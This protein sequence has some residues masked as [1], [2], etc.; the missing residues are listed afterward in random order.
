MSDLEAALEAVLARIKKYRHLYEQNE[1]A[2]RDQIVNPILRSLGW[3]T[4]NP[5]EVQPNVSMEEGVPDYSLLKG[6]KPVLFM[7]AK[8][9]GVDVE[10]RD[11]IRQ[12]AK[13]G[14]GEGTKYGILTNGVVWIL[15]KSFE[16]GTTLAERAVWKVDLERERSEATL[17]K[18]NTI[19]RENIGQIENLV[20]RAQ[21]LEETWASILEEPQEMVSG[22]TPVV[23]NLI[24]EA[25]PGYHFEDG[26]IED[27]VK[28]RLRDMI[29]GIAPAAVTYEDEGALEPTRLH[30]ERPRRMKLAGE[31][32]ELQNA[33]EILVNTANWLIRKGRLKAT[34]CPIPAGYK[35]YLIHKEPKHRYGNGFRAPRKLIGGLYIETHYSTVA[36]INNARVLLETYGFPPDML[37]VQ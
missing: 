5:E 26:E 32:F 1:M 28:E 2:V 16:E 22:L 24:S 27:F 30:G 33:F 31:S 14:F 36:C 9:L 19:S 10:Q 17:R 4:E 37:T 7:E 18:L 8:K 15:F 34:D 23:Q 11:I 21:I 20:R 25:Y 29:L 13:Y 12:L 6:A 35:R 3:N